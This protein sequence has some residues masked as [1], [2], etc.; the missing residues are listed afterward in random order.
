MSSCLRGLR[1][2]RDASQSLTGLVCFS[3][4]SMQL[5]IC[6]IDRFTMPAIPCALLVWK[7]A[8]MSSRAA[9][10]QNDASALASVKRALKT[11]QPRLERGPVGLD[12]RPRARPGDGIVEEGRE[13]PRRVLRANVAGEGALQGAVDDRGIAERRRREQVALALVG[14]AGPRRR[15]DQGVVQP[16]VAVFG[17]DPHDGSRPATGRARGTCGASGLPLR[18]ERAIERGARLPNDIPVVPDRAER[19]DHDARGAPGDR[20]CPTR[21]AKSRAARTAA[22]ASSG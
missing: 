18:G 2:R 6:S 16:V 5:L 15:G 3:R 20:R 1:Y 9:Q 19:A 22:A 17:G 14:R 7:N 4:R 11:L 12:E 10:S 21:R 13:V 8:L